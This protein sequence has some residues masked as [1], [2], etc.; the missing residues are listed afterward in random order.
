MRV[1]KPVRTLRGHT[2]VIMSLAFSP[3][4]QRLASGSRDHTVKFSD[5]R[6]GRNRQIP[7]SLP[8]NNHNMNDVTRILTE[9]EQGNARTTDELLPSFTMNCA[10]WPRTRWPV[11]EPRAQAVGQAARHVARQAAAG[12]VGQALDRAGGADRLQQRLHV[13]ARRLEQRLA[14]DAWRTARRA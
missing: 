12:D 6:D 3:D 2:G 1:G 9:I 13:D 7:S 4:G 14:S 11:I 5:R 10:V 8:S